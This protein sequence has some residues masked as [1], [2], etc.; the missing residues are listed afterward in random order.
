MSNP[1]C[2]PQLQHE[3]CAPRLP[4]EQEWKVSNPL[5]TFMYTANTF[6]LRLRNSF[7]CVGGTNYKPATNKAG[8][9]NFNTVL[10]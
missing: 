8:L 3:D 5:G 7:K 2:W 1:H 6:T 9:N 10:Y 4:V